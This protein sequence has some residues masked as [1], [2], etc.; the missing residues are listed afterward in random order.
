[1]NTYESA[2]TIYFL[3]NPTLLSIYLVRFGCKLILKNIVG[4]IK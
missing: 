2:Y 1:M 4:W 3:K